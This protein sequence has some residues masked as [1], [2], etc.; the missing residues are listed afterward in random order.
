M[1]DVHEPNFC[2]FPSRPQL[3]WL[4]LVISFFFAA[5]I[6]NGGERKKEYLG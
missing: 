6:L 4:R 1:V 3:S 2:G 5:E